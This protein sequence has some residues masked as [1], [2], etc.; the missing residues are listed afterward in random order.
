[1]NHGFL[2]WVGLV[3]KAGGAME[4]GTVVGGISLAPPKVG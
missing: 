4:S 2:F 3:D 1:M